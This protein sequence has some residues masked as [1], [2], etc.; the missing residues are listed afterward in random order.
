[1][2]FQ[3]AVVRTA[4]LGASAF[5]YG[6]QALG[7]NSS[8]IRAANTRSLVGSVALEIAL[9]DRYPNDPLWDYGVG[10]KQSARVSALWIELH[11]ASTSEVRTVLRKLEWLKNWLKDR[12]PALQKLTG[13]Q[14]YFWVATGGV[15]IRQGSPQ[16]RLLQSAGLSMPRKRIDL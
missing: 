12:A 14:S 8:K 2:T 10:V 6:L 16:A 7:N 3:E 4:D 1:M 9:R 13:V 11:P 15:H 5:R